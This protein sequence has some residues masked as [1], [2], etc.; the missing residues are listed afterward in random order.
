LKFTKNVKILTAN[1]ISIFLLKPPAATNDIA[2]KN[3]VG[4]RLHNGTVTAVFKIGKKNKAL[5]PISEGRAFRYV[6][7]CGIAPF[8]ST[9]SIASA[10]N[11]FC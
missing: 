3:V 8:V 2:V 7:G 11:R 10:N 6:V 4:Q 9:F 1:E 5:P